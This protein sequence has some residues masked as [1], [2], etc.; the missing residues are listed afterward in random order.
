M[1]DIGH[2]KFVAL[3]LSAKTQEKLLEFVKTA[4]LDY[5]TN[6]DYTKKE[7]PEKTDY[8]ITLLSSANPPNGFIKNGVVPTK[9]IYLKPRRYEILV[10]IMIV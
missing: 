8:H 10:Q 9:A 7:D 3:N 1:I 6:F 5:T 4:G 2:G